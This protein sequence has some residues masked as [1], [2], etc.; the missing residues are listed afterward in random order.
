MKATKPRWIS[1]KKRL[2][3]SPR[4][5]LVCTLGWPNKWNGPIVLM[6]EYFRK[7][8]ANGRNAHWRVVDIWGNYDE[9]YL[10]VSD[11]AITRWMELPPA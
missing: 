5:V 2:P 6:G 8:G 3:D 7:K 11:G 4:T 1:I 10:F 9:P